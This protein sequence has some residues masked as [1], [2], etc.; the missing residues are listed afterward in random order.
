LPSQP[1]AGDRPF[2][3][4]P[5]MLWIKVKSVPEGYLINQFW[6][7]FTEKTF[8]YVYDFKIP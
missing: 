3:A 7:K 6:L 5:E 4:W 2:T 8:T 1:K